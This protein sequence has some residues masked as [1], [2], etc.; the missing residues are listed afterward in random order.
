MR[1]LRRR[2]MFSL[3]VTIIEPQMES[4][5]KTNEALR[6][7]TGKESFTNRSEKPFNFSFPPG[8]IGIGSRTLYTALSLSVSLSWRASLTR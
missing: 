2:C 5:V 4:F 3:V 1:R 7:K 8:L 6:L